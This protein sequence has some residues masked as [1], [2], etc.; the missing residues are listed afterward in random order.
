LPATLYVLRPTSAARITVVIV[1]VYCAI[2]VLMQRKLGRLVQGGDS[3]QPLL[4]RSEW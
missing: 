3:V 2:A 4:G 1:I